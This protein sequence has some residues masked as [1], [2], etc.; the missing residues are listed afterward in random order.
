MKSQPIGSAE[1]QCEFFGPISRLDFG[2]LV[3][4]GEVF[5]SEFFWGP[6]LLEKQDHEFGS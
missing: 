4:G 6:L 1:A 5:E 3:L 2:R